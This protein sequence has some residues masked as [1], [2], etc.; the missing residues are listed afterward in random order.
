MGFWIFMLCMAE[1][2]P[3]LMMIFGVFFM[4]C[5]PEDINKLYGYRTRRSMKDQQAWDFAQRYWGWCSLYTGL[6]GLAPTVLCMLPCLGRT[7]D[8]IG[9]WGSVVCVV[10]CAAVIGMPVFL[11][12]EALKRREHG[13]LAEK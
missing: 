12:E 13:A 11:T 10:A 8:E 1:V 7:V 9:I 3:V 6:V 5:P 4:K 2:S